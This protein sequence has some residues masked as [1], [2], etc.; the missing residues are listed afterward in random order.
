MLSALPQVRASAVLW[1]FVGCGVWS[2]SMRTL[3]AAIYSSFVRN[4]MSLLGA[5]S[6]APALGAH[7]EAEWCTLMAPA[8]KVAVRSAMSRL[9]TMVVSC[10]Y[11]CL[12]TFV[13]A[14]ILEMVS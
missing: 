1:Q 8:S 10:F 2:L 5:W 4:L 12:A 9:R 11:W 14:V 13:S 3:A 7:V 6:L